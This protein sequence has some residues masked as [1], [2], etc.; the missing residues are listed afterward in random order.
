[1]QVSEDAQQEYTQTHCTAKQ[2][3]EHSRNIRCEQNARQEAEARL[4]A[5]HGE[6]LLVHDPP[7]IT[8]FSSNLER[9]QTWS[10]Q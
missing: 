10:V 5:V 1:M 8:V 3:L 2:E 4:R 6:G 9:V 7:A